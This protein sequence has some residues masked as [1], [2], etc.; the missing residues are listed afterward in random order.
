M[1]IVTAQAELGVSDVLLSESIDIDG[2]H[3][4]IEERLTHLLGQSIHR[5]LASDGPCLVGVPVTSVVPLTRYQEIRFT[6]R[7]EMLPLR[8][9]TRDDL[10]AW[11]RSQGMEVP[12]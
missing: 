10:N 3:R 7:S 4:D 8:G 12:E 11:F 9:M 6:R 5:T 2:L 1:S